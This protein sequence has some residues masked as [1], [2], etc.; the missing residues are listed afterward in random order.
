[1]NKGLV[2]VYAIVNAVEN[3]TEQHIIIQP[4]LNPQVREEMRTIIRDLEKKEKK[5]AKRTKKAGDTPSESE[6]P[7]SDAKGESE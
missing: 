1:M 3:L 2:S 7:N 4:G 6:V 5:S